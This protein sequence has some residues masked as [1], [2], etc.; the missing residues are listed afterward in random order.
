[1]RTTISFEGVDARTVQITD[2]SA[3]R[4]ETVPCQVC[5]VVR[6]CEGDLHVHGLLVESGW[7]FAVAPVSADAKLPQFAVT[8]GA[9]TAAGHTRLHVRVPRDAEIRLA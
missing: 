8:I 3:R 7:V 6:S 9:A 4:D 5:W 1:M 2:V